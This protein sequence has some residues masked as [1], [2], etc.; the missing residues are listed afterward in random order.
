MSVAKKQIYYREKYFL[1]E[2]G[3]RQGV[4]SPDLFNLSSKVILSELDILPGFIVHESNINN[5]N[6]W[7][8]VDSKQKENLDNI[9]K[10][11][12]KKR[13]TID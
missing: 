12:E 9:V 7:H 6:R 8:S 4:F 13:L 3:V 10:E 2:I 5:I 11:F 1:I